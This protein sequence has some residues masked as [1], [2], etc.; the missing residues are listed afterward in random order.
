MAWIATVA[1]DAARGPLA[2]LYEAATRRAGK[3]YHIVQLMS[4]QPKVL[5][6]SMALYAATTTDAD[7][8]LS[9]WFRE[10]IAVTV[11]RINRCEY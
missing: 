1:P 11:S 10:L 8:P 2:A 4:P 9:R 6:T 5:Q 7:S 3:V